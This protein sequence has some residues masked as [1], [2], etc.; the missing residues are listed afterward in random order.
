[1]IKKRPVDLEER[2]REGS[3]KGWREGNLWF[4]CIVWEN[5]FPSLLDCSGEI[6][7][8]VCFP[9]YLF[10]RA[11]EQKALS[12]CDGNSYGFPRFVLCFFISLSWA[13]WRV[14][15][16]LLMAARD[17]LSGIRNLFRLSCVMWKQ[18]LSHHFS[19]VLDSLVL[20]LGHSMDGKFQKKI[21]PSGSRKEHWWGTIHLC[22]S[23]ACAFVTRST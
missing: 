19:L 8:E 22:Y 4:R 2:G 21:K 16:R 17:A 15:K 13:A 20:L 23:S 3:W 9:A 11:Q 14:R 6:F 12:L 10:W 5:L 7:W 18:T 1:M